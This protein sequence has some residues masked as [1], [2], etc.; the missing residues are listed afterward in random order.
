MT[1]HIYSSTT[2]IYHLPSNTG[3][4][5]SVKTS[6]NMTAH[7][8]SFSS[9]LT[10]HYISALPQMKLLLNISVPTPLLNAR[11]QLANKSWLPRVQDEDLSRVHPTL[12]RA[13]PDRTVS[14]SHCFFLP[15]LSLRLLC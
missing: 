14:L 4:F 10:S 12:A 5:N 7:I 9:A 11:T 2:Q 6:H 13:G 1:A 3:S 15:S 8:Y